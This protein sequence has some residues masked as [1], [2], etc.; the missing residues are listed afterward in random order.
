MTNEI[1]T[2]CARQQASPSEADDFL[3]RAQ[4]LG[5]RLTRADYERTRA[6]VAAFLKAERI[7]L[8]SPSASTDPVDEERKAPLPDPC[9]S[10]SESE[11]S[12][13][14]Q[15]SSVDPPAL[16]RWLRTTSGQL[17]FFTAVV[18]QH[19][20]EKGRLRISL[21]DVGSAEER[22]RRRRR[23]RRILEKQMLLESMP[24]SPPLPGHDAVPQ[25]PR[26]CQ[27]LRSSTPLS[28]PVQPT[29]PGTDDSRAS[30][31]SPS[32][33][34]LNVLNRMA[35]MDH[36]GKLW[37]ASRH[38]DAFDP[39]SEDSTALNDDS[40]VFY[41]QDK[42]DM[43]G[44]GPR[45]FARSNTDN[46]DACMKSMSLLD[47]IMLSKT[48]PRRIRRE[49][50]ERERLRVA[51][52][53]TLEH[54]QPTYVDAKD[55]TPDTSMANWADVSS[56]SSGHKR[57]SSS[58]GGRFL[59]GAS[60]TPLHRPPSSARGSYDFVLHDSSPEK[61]TPA[62]SM[63]DS[64]LRTRRC[65]SRTPAKRDVDEP[66]ASA[67]PLTKLD[68]NMQI[69]P[70]RFSPEYGLACAHASMFS[71]N[72]LTPWTHQ[73]RLMSNAGLAA[74]PSSPAD[75]E[76]PARQSRANFAYSSTPLSHLPFGEADATNIP[77]VV[78]SPNRL[79]CI[80][81]FPG[82]SPQQRAYFARNSPVKVTHA[83]PLADKSNAR[84]LQVSPA[85]R[86]GRAGL[87]R[88]ALETPWDKIPFQRTETISPADIFHPAAAAWPAPPL[89]EAEVCEADEHD[90]PSVSSSPETASHR[91]RTGRRKNVLQ[92]TPSVASILPTHCDDVFAKDKAPDP[93]FGEAFCQVA[94]HDGQTEWEQPNGSKIV[95]L[96]SEELQAAIDSGTLDHEP[97]PR[98]YRLPPGYGTGK[99]KPSSVSYAGLI[100]QAI[101]SSSDSRLS[102]AEIYNWIS[103]VYPFY[104]RGD[105]GW[106]NSIRHNLSL[107]KSFVK[108][109]RESTIP[110]KGGWWAI[111]PGHEPRFK[112]GL[113]VP[114]ASRNEPVQ[115]TRAFRSS[116]SA[117]AHALP[118]PAKDDVRKRRTAVPAAEA[119]A[120]ADESRPDVSRQLFKRARTVQHPIP[121]EHVGALCDVANTS[122]HLPLLTD[123]TS[124]PDT[125][126]M[127]SFSHDKSAVMHGAW[128]NQ[129]MFAQSKQLSAMHMQPMGEIAG[130]PA[131]MY[132]NAVHTKPV[133]TPYL[134]PQKRSPVTARQRP[135]Y[136][137]FTGPNPFHS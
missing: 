78:P 6:G 1:D 88:T 43:L 8:G 36:G 20:G 33:P 30:P 54:L 114:S 80:E 106:Q 118:S 85:L 24:L 96:V 31:S 113:Y 100:G 19:A 14:R 99:A 73:G 28:R 117:P 15:A 71:P 65:S 40:G 9:L 124:S 23:R 41:E 3:A 12:V 56:E 44:W 51:P 130:Y 69:T 75:W 101:L 87:S 26:R 84:Q 77:Q 27:L 45:P 125:S 70:M 58:S 119:G 67:T 122:G 79:L 93:M 39:K 57:Q 21:D 48:S 120:D 61:S 53:D 111:V 38:D 11:S 121:F 47:R 103:T 131:P 108:L 133:P 76:A 34:E 102:L 37:L 35:R 127:H 60:S 134:S 2:P 86:T 17:G 10:P 123:S 32:S 66:S 74:V 97:E 91:L 89:I 29:P 112:N 115:S 104:E 107:N 109:E 4:A 13:S 22:R 92:R 136:S 72:L 128:P 105:R 50:K 16:S 42:S 126:P 5:L 83:S 59:R 18:R 63:L 116:Y 95:K 98:F 49:A 137:P 68:P 81:S 64:P 94:V 135:A 62:R 110:G 90:L 46:L 52:F 82:K 55:D 7:P 132:M 25:T 129:G